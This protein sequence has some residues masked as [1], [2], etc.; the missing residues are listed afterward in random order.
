M[1]NIHERLRQL[2]EEINRHDYL[3][4]VLAS[5][6]ITDRDYDSLY[7]ELREIEL[8][9]PAL[10]T[11]DSPTQR[12]GGQPLEAFEEIEHTLPMMSLENTYSKDEVLS[13]DTRT[14]KLLHGEEL[15]YIVE[16]K[17][18]GVAVSLRYEHGKL[19]T[20][21]TRGN[22]RVGDNVTANIRTIRT[23]P[24]QITGPD[25]ECPVFEVRGEIFMP[26]SSFVQLNRKREAAGLAAFANPRNAAA[27]SLKLLDPAMVAA[28]PLD[29]IMYGTGMVAGRS[30]PT[31]CSFLESLKADGIKTV[32][33]Y[34][35]CENIQAVLT[36]LDQLQ[37]RRHDFE[38]EI[39]GAVIKVNENN[40]NRKLGATARNPRS[41]IAYKYDPEQARTTVTGIR[42]Q[43]G[44]TG[45]LTPVADLDPVKISGSVVSRATLHNEDEIARKDIRVGD[46][47]VV[48]KAGE[49][50][51]SVVKVLFEERTGSE[52]VF[53]MPPRC[54]TCAGP[55]TRREGEV[56]VRC[57]NLQCPAQLKRRVN[58]FASSEAMDI[59]GLGT[60]LV[61]QLVDTQLI[62]DPADIYTLQLESLL[63]LER[64]GHRSAEKLLGNIV[65]SKQREYHRVIFA[66][67]IPHVGSQN[68]RLLAESFPSMDELMNATPQRL[69]QVPTIGPT[70]A[71]S[72]KR[73]F[74]HP[75][76]IP[77]I[78][79]LRMAGIQ[80]QS[81]DTPAASLKLEGLRFVLT[82]TLPT[83]GR[84]KA[85][86]RIRREGG[87]VSSSV[88]E[89]T[90]Y[91]LAG[92]KPG[93]KMAKAQKLGV[94]ILDEAEFIRLL[95]PK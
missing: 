58:H 57:E 32:P 77:V 59:E 62:S 81:A 29:A 4:Y 89:K 22:G 35:K 65:L 31:H 72:I 42:V 38:F 26:K 36:R 79:K 54:P 70:V 17:I 80:M 51:P 7:S 66:L 10:I 56:A 68:A 52:S 94:R 27:G 13:F 76:N 83:L 85:S 33:I 64:M 37:A 44:R 63:K 87:S 3:Y 86:E 49:I 74:A 6:E 84:K 11:P 95:D 23:I 67:G 40:L 69:E 41:A 39:D 78:D 71:E 55:V 46:S 93:S 50:I 1:K 60:S 53:R 91:L 5:P 88:S 16:P 90:D 21:A 61:E 19:L 24:L 43:V 25:S 34:W 8:A 15:T 82:G 9:D 18:D 28:R 2:R 12:V 73:F 75:D 45:V 14:R 47:V 92:D 48:E 30:F 20:G